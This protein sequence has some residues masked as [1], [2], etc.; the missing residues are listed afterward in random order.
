MFCFIALNEL[1]LGGHSAL[2]YTAI[3]FWSLH[4]AVRDLRNTT[5][6]GLRVSSCAQHTY[7]K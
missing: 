4:I 3:T 7:N 6:L 5:H 2:C 1:R